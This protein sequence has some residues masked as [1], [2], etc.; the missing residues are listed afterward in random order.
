MPSPRETRAAL[1][2]LTGEAVQTAAELLG[3]LGGA[4]EQQR[5]ALLSTVPGLIDYYA[6]G[7]AALALDF[8]D[9]QR[10]MVGQTSVFTSEFVVNDR[11]VKIRRA[12]AWAS[13]PLF[14]E[15]LDAAAARL[16]EVVQLETARPFRDTI[17]AN[18]RRDPAAVGW[19]RVTAGGCGFCRML[20]DRGAVYKEATARFAAHTNCHCIAQ[21]VFGADDFGEEADALQYMASRRSRTPEQR[22]VLRE[23]IAT[24]YPD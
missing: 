3:R 2:V 16:G 24:H 10:Q 14:T 12:V 13:A 15:D 18:R 9:E 21:P 23:F 5:A 20:A 19:R 6:D 4:P 17:T 22:A 7:S 1:K 8:Y 11:T